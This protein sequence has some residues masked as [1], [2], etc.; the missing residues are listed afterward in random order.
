MRG[1]IIDSVGLDMENEKE[2][3]EMMTKIEKPRIEEFAC[4]G[5][6]FQMGCEFRIISGETKIALNFQ[7]LPKTS[8]NSYFF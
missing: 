4:L 2:N 6:K 5:I 1:K 8:Q 7:I 3:H